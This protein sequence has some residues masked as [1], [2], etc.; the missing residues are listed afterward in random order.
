MAALLARAGLSLLIACIAVAQT[1]PLVAQ[2]AWVRA[3]PGSDVAA[4]Y[5]TLHNVSA[6][7]VIVTGVQSAIATHAMIHETTVQAG[8]SRRRAQ[9]RLVIAPG[10]TIQLAPGGLH[11]ML[12]GLTRPLAVGQTVP[13]VL[14]LAGG[15]TL[16]VAA[17][18]RPLN[19]E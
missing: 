17:P 12:H 19:A 10:Q 13:L 4:V 8:Q 16:Q 3:T 1:A 5:L 6:K 9:A 11:V 2:N 18:V 14:M 7:P 15:E